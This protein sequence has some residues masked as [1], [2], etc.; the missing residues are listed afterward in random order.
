MAGAEPLTPLNLLEYQEIARRLLPPMHYDYIAGASGD[1]VT[2]R[3]NREAF[4]RW[5]MVPR[6]LRGIK[7][8]DLSTRVMG[9]DVSMPVLLS[10]VGFQ[11]LAHD[12]GEVASAAAAKAA[13]TIF[14]LSTLST[15]TMEDVAA[16]AGTWWFQLYCYSDRAITRDLIQRAE[17]AGASAIVV[18][19]D[20]PLLGRREADERNQFSLP[21]GLE[22]ANLLRSV[23]RQMPKDAGGSGLAAY[24]ASLW[25]PAL[26]WDEI[27]WVAS[28]TKLPMG[29]K[30]ILASEDAALAV[31]HG[32]RLVVVSN[33]G[34]RQLD[35]SIATLDALPTVM[36]VVDSRCQVVLDGGIR[37]GTDVLKALALGATAV[38]IGRP[39]V[40]GLA[41]AGREGA[42]RVLG[43]L[44][45]ELRLD[46]LLAGCAS[47][48]DVDRSLLVRA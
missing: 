15:C 48:A 36:E 4:D 26:S 28:A 14:T 40:W 1:Q 31:E 46:M 37:R 34:G 41:T 30:G 19:V 22:L 7:S 42:A 25:D 29:I 32:A 9:M 2:L 27:D 47:P 21:E 24:I 5:R 38:M 16:E 11:R 35:H 43:M 45:E 10:P 8:V 12:D 39:Y 33:H 20:S 17:A 23:Y 6:V 44:R 3:A 13:A 18:T